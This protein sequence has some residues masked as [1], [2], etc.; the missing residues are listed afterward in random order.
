M[1]DGPGWVPAA[2]QA[3][4]GPELVVPSSAR[5]ARQPAASSVEAVTTPSAAAEAHAVL[6]IRPSRPRIV[7]P[8]SSCR[9]AEVRVTILY[10]GGVVVARF[11]T[12]LR[13]VVC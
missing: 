4:D 13:F 2:A 3:A 9:P 11:V 1:G 6:V 8:S 5:C 12:A 10:A 7:P